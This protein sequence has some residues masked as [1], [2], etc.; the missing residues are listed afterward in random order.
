MFLIVVSM[1]VL[2]VKEKRIMDTTVEVGMSGMRI[3]I[4]KIKGDLTVPFLLIRFF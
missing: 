2:T 1:F 4:G 3:M